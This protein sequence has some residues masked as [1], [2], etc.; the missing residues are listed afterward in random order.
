MNPTPITYHNLQLLIPDQVYSPAEDTDLAI[1]FLERWI[2]RFLNPD[3]VPPPP[4]SVKIL[5]LGIGP[6]TLS[7]L[8]VHSLKGST[9]IPSI[10]GVD[11]NPFAVEAARYNASLNEL[12]K[13]ITVF[14]GD[15]FSPLS[16]TE[17][18]H[19]F[20]LVVFNPPYLAS[21]SALITPMTR[22][23]IDTAWEGGKE[24]YELTLAFLDGLD[25]FIHASSEIVFLASDL[26][27]QQPILTKLHQKNI[28]VINRFT[29][30]IFFE[31]ILLYYCKPN[32]T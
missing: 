17:Y 16:L 21:D 26:V 14:E 22:Q 11:I 30:H 6:G 5:E 25:P 1:R 3:S 28:N 10:I 20:D 19:V 18:A 31:T 7:L 23:P 32:L 13:Y 27:D 15:L 8:L 29:Q 24:G 12:D 2:I 4:P 9:C